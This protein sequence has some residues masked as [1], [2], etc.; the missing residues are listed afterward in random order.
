L[1]LKPD[2]NFQSKNW[3]SMVD[4]H[5]PSHQ[6]PSRGFLYPVFA[7]SIT[8]D[9]PMPDVKPNGTSTVVVT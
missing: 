6:L 9:V 8:S 5:H 7:A 1:S 3:V 4:F 2:G